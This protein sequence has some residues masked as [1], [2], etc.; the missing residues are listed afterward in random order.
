MKL[1]NLCSPIAGHRLPRLLLFCAF[2]FLLIASNALNGHAQT[3]SVRPVARLITPSG[4]GATF[5][6][7]PRT[8]SA[9]SG[10]GVVMSPAVAAATSDERR[11]FDLVNAERRARGERPLAWDAELMQMARRH[12]QNMA[13]QNFFNHKGPDGQG[14]RERSRASGISGFRALA[15][16][17][18]Y[19][20][21][22]DD[23]ASCAVVGWMQSAGHRD[24]ILN[25]E[26]TRSGIG[27]ARAA[28]GRV[29]ITQVFIAR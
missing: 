2:S 16:N 26:F 21:G 23:V 29:Y 6:S 18:A 20:K 11:A 9:S 7:R 8:V 15:E 27:I 12:S 1:L 14:L 10:I 17:L 13:R 19:N 3:N 22:F 28:D 24:N 5:S 25:A 4:D